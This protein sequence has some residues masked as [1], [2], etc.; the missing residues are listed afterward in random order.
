MSALRI[1]KAVAA[2]LAAT[3]FMTVNWSGQRFVGRKIAHAVVPMPS[4]RSSLS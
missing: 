3:W 4:T 1:A 2:G